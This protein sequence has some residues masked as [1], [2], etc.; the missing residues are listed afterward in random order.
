VTGPRRR[1]SVHIGQVSAEEMAIFLKEASDRPRVEPSGGPGAGLS[2]AEAAAE[3]ARCLHCDCRKPESCRLRRLAESLQAKAGRYKGQ[4]RRRFVQDRAAGV[5]YESGKCIDCG[6]CIRIA[7]AAREPLGL[8][9]VGRGFNVRV[10]V[11]FSRALEEGLRRCA[12]ECA[13]ACP[14]GALALADAEE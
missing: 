1:F 4:E 11:P 2:S 3:A 12:A 6:I 8:A 9:F 13:A 10:G 14:T 7:A 5:V